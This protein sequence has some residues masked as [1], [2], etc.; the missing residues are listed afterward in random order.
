VNLH[1]K[2]SA[3]H[4]TIIIQ[5]YHFFYLGILKPQGKTEVLVLGFIYLHFNIIDL[6]LPSPGLQ[7]PPDYEQ[8]RFAKCL[9]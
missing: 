9:S 1:L 7:S 4:N 3:H 5:N 6:Y 2:L 8:W